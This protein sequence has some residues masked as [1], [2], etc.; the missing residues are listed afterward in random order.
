MDPILLALRHATKNKGR[1]VWLVDVTLL[2][3]S[4]P[5]LA[6][7]DNPGD[8]TVDGIDY[9]SYPVS[10]DPP[11]CGDDGLP[12]A[13]LRISNVLRAIQDSLWANDFYRLATVRMT[14]YNTAAP[15]ADYSD[16]VTVL[17][18]VSEKSSQDDVV[19]TLGVPKELTDLVPEDSYGPYNC[20]HRFGRS[21]C[22]YTAPAIEGVTLSG[23]DPVL[24]TQTGH[25]YT[26]GV[27]V[28]IADCGGISPSLDGIYDVTV[29]DASHFRLD[30]TVSSAYS[31][32][33]NS[34]GTAGYAYCARHFRDC[35]AR[36]RQ[37]TFGGQRG[38]RVDGLRI[39]V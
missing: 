14:E 2:G 19:F 33:W 27:E 35:I 13:E 22:G 38:C 10:L 7:T 30:G 36:V 21:R 29:V 12:T 24:I 8:L 39:A 4:T 23:S 6:V 34:G 1:E 32:S 20:R 28:A 25:G 16:Q 17:Q 26:T 11:T 5:I 3:E 9:V 37:T 31:G 15:S 18:V